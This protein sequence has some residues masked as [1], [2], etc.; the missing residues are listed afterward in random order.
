MLRSCSGNKAVNVMPVNMLKSFHR[1]YFLTKRG[2]KI[3]SSEEEYNPLEESD[4]EEQVSR[5]GH[6]CLYI[7][8]VNVGVSGDFD[9]IEF[10]IKRVLGCLP[11]TAG[12]I[13]VL[14]LSD[15]ELRLFKHLSDEVIFRYPYLVK[16]VIEYFDM[17]C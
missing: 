5:M 1:K 9:R 13:S 7:G 12:H 17:I 14:Q 10:G 2:K 8:S 16:L 6:M 15:M 4:D 11:S 3:S